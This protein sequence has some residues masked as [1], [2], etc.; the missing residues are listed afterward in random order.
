MECK[1]KKDIEF[2]KSY[3]SNLTS[4]SNMLVGICSLVDCSGLSEV[5]QLIGKAQNLKSSY[6]KNRVKHSQ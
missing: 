3:L 6:F 5:D 1:E 2:K 4:Q